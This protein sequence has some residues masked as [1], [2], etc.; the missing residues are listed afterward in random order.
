MIA[1]HTQQSPTRRAKQAASLALFGLGV[2]SIV[3]GAIAVPALLVAG[4]LMTV[5]AMTVGR[6][7]LDAPT[8]LIVFL[9]LTLLI[10]SRL[11][12]PQ[13]GAA[14]TPALLF[15]LLMLGAWC[16][17]RVFSMLDSN[18]VRHPLRGAAAFIILSLLASYVWAAI[19]RFEGFS[20]VNLDR[21]LMVFFSFVG[22][23]LFVADS[24]MTRDEVYR[25]VDVMLIMGGVVALIGIVQS[26][27]RFDPV[28]YIQIPGLSGG[29]LSI[30]ERFGVRRVTSTARHPI[31]FSVVIATMVPIAI[32]RAN[33]K[34][35]ANRS[36]FTYGLVALMLLSLAT[37]VSRSGIVALMA[38]MLMLLPAMSQQQRSTLLA[39]TPVILVVGRAAFPGVI[40]TLRGL[41]LNFG[42]DNSVTY[43]LSDYA[44]VEGFIAETPIL[45]RGVRT[46][47]A[48]RFVLLDNQLLLTVI[49]SGLVGLLAILVYFAVGVGLARGE[50]LRTAASDPDH[51]QFA[52]ALAAGLIALLVS[53][54]T[55]DA[56]HY[57]MI[58]GLTAVVSGLAACLWCASGGYDNPVPLNEWAK[59]LRAYIRR[60]RSAVT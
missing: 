8:I 1:E 32:A 10:P 49:E 47:D 29:V 18:T 15:G 52:Q 59:R 53:F 44:A 34:W 37:A 20:F 6:V 58:M 27:L 17:S 46:F 57:S 56:T 42:S 33:A 31:E 22:V 12:F 9:G 51:S 48:E 30:R 35:Q 24:K 26:M 38:A 43:R 25:V 23:A 55:F 54:A 13:I 28:Q 45:G 40:G 19:H 4:V 36:L 60:E 50:R 11:V 16:L 7:E 21:G 5:A 39:M 14:G 41:F 3:A 2:T